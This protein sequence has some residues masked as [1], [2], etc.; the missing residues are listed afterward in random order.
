MKFDINFILITQLLQ[1]VCRAD[2]VYFRLS[3]ALVEHRLHFISEHMSYIRFFHNDG[4]GFR[5]K[6]CF[7]VVDNDFGNVIGRF[8]MISQHK[9]EM[10]W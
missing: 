6:C 3:N 2:V 5:P 1:R 9:G 8:K 7:D 4:N 10:R